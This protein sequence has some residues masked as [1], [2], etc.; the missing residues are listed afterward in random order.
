MI[1]RII[2]TVA[3]LV[4]AVTQPVLAQRRQRAARHGDKPARPLA[5]PA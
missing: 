4:V 3:V 2:S 5:H 1:I